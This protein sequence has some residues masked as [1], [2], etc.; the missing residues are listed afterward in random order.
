MA[1]TPSPSNVV[2]PHPTLTEYYGSAP[3]K[4]PFLT[5]IFDATAVDYDRI[6]RMMAF[7][8]GPWYRRQALKRAGLAEGMK[9]LDVAVGTGLVAREEI[10]L[11]GSADL[12]LGLDPS[13]GMLS[14]A[15][16]ALKIRAL[17]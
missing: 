17:L 12:V 16:K 3:S 5:K 8:T 15:V 11:T 13:L 10:R 7:G 1:V 6:E 4:R 2:P 9:V 14:Q